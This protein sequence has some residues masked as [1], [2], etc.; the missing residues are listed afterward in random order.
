M[1]QQCLYTKDASYEAKST[2]DNLMFSHHSVKS[3]LSQCHVKNYYKSITELQDIHL[4]VIS[5]N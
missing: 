1:S 4:F 3:Y 5:S 2:G